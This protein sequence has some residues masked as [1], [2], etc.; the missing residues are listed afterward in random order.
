MARSRGTNVVSFQGPVPDGSDATLVQSS[1]FASQFAG[2]DI[3]I[4][5]IW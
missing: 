5:A 2:D 3:M 1:S 4:H